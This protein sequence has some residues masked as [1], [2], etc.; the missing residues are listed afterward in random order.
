MADISKFIGRKS[1]QESI[2]EKF[3]KL[4]EGKSKEEIREIEMNLLK[5]EPIPFYN[6]KK[7]HKT[8]NPV[9]Q[10]SIT[11][12]F[13]DVKYIDLWE[14]YFKISRNIKNNTYHVGFLIEL[15][16]LLEQGKL[17]YD[18]KKNR[19]YRKLSDGRLRRL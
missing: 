17:E 10:K 4:I 18:E 5:P 15:F 19:Y 3:T 2:I 14:K 1:Q 9:H 12:T 13:S 6:Q 16:R 7:D 11:V 8:N